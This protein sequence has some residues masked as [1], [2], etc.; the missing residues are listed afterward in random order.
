MAEFAGGH[1]LHQLGDRVGLLAAHDLAGHDLAHRLLQ[2]AGTAL[3]EHAHDVALG[4]D[5]FEPA[6]V[7]HQHCTDLLLAEQL[8][9][10]SQLRVGLDAHDLVALGV[11]N[12]TYRHCRLPESHPSATRGPDL[13]ASLQLTVWARVSR[14]GALRSSPLFILEHDLSGKPSHTFRIM[15]E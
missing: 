6:L 13:L 1:H 4:Q 7:H 9:R 8:D 2:H 12:G 5:A 10:G 3:T 14:A 15:L 11:E